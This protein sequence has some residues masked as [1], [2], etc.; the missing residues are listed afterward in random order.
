MSKA[1]REREESRETR[2]IG[3]SRDHAVNQ[4]L[5]DHPSSHPHPQILSRSW[6][7]RATRVT[8]VSPVRLEPQ[9]SPAR[10]VTVETMVCQ[11]FP[12]RTVCRECKARREIP[13]S[14]A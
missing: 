5:R 4:A 7:K 1:S 13:A 14:L 6:E 12:E 2:E 11:E 10:R 8:A 9:A 3:E